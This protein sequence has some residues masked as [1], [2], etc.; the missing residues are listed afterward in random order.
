MQHTR[1]EI[2]GIPCERVY[3]MLAAFM[4]N[5]RQQVHPHH[6]VSVYDNNTD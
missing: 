2:R 3:I 4:H 5:G 1:V 6:I